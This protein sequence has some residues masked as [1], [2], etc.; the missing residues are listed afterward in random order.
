MISS[1]EPTSVLPNAIEEVH[2]FW[3]AGG[4]CDGCSIAAVGASS[5]SV[6]E[7]I[8]GTLPGIAKVVLHHPVLAVNAGEEFMK[9]FRLAAKG[10]LGHPFVVLCEGS[11][12]DESLAGQTGGYWSGLGAD[13]DEFGDPSTH[14]FCKLD[15][16]NV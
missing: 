13:K 8:N 2:A 7:L 1:P 10:E 12:M 16:K 3:I 15:H 6:E 5:P 9:P 11:I 4:S 14:T